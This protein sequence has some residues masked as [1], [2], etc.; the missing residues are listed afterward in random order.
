MIARVGTTAFGPPAKTRTG[1]EVRT[2]TTLRR[3]DLRTMLR[4]LGAGDSFSLP[5]RSL[6]SALAGSWRLLAGE[7]KLVVDSAHYQ[8][9]SLP[10]GHQPWGS[11]VTCGTALPRQSRVMSS[12]WVCPSRKR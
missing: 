4:R 11:C 10:I 9:Q 8:E 5:G 7:S 3:A 6:A 1:K 2:I 12:T